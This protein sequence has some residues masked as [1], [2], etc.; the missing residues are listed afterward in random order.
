MTESMKTTTPFIISGEGYF[1]GS[2]GQHEPTHEQL[3]FLG[4]LAK[5][6]GK[7][8]K[9]TDKELT[10]I[11]ELERRIRITGNSFEEAYLVAGVAVVMSVNNCIAGKNEVTGGLS[12]AAIYG[13]TIL[14]HGNEIHP[15]SEIGD[16]GLIGSF[17]IIKARLGADVVVGR[18]NIIG[19]PNREV[20][21]GDKTVIL[22]DAT[23]V[24]SVGSGVNVG[25]NAS[26]T[27]YGRVGN[28]WTIGYGA[29]VATE[30][31][32]KPE[33][34]EEQRRQSWAETPSHAVYANADNVVS[35][36]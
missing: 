18:C 17:N 33:R 21:I 10:D 15:Y 34:S 23:I 32:D 6:R 5:E 12:P 8:F 4:R 2:D 7:G 3:E 35:D 24:S 28:N 9:F 16:G 31:P 13:A 27:S 30:L 26:V 19:H 14:G 36:F 1:G 29:V 22:D 25:R 20:S 11:E